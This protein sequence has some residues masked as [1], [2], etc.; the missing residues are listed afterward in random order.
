MN[1]NTKVDDVNGKQ[2]LAKDVFT[3]VIDFMKNHLMR[4]VTN[5]VS[6]IRESDVLFVIT[7][8][9]IWNEAS[10]QFMR[11]AAIAVCLII[12][13]HLKNNNTPFDCFCIVS[14]ILLKI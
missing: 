5:Q 2:M 6:N 3:L 8:P 4:A 10:K 13:N 9:A 12:F 14:Y 7:V 11:E 1:R